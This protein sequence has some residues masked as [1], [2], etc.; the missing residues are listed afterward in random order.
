MRYATAAALLF[1]WIASANAGSLDR[2]NAKLAGRV[3]DYTHNHGRDN[4]VVSRILCMKR[5]LYVY[6]PPC[7]DPSV[8]YP[9]VLWLHGGFGNETSFFTTPQL[10]YLDRMIRCGK[11]PPVIVAA[12][13]GNYSGRNFLLANH[14]L[15]VNGLGGRVQDHVM[16]EV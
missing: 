1:V 9:L 10:T 15:F 3:V 7:H 2:L 14:S 12:P 8:S 5:D 11:I 4:R 6:L 16:M 13:D